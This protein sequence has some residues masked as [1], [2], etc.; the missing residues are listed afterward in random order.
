[1]KTIEEQIKQKE[2]ELN[3]LKSQLIQTQQV[4]VNGNL[5]IKGKYSGYQDNDKVVF[6][7]GQYN[8]GAKFGGSQR[9]E[10]AKFKDRMVFDDDT[11]WVSGIYKREKNGDL[12]E[13]KL[14]KA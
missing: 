2:K 7:G 10:G 6:E 11:E 9:N 4:D 8:I 1:M 12:V 13:Y 3:I 5:I 14:V